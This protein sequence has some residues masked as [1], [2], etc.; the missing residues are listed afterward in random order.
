MSDRPTAAIEHPADIQVGRPLP[1]ETIRATEC[2]VLV[3]CS[4]IHCHWQGL[5]PDAELAKEAAETHYKHEGRSGTGHYGSRTYTIVRL[6]DEA[7][8]QTVDESVLGLSVEE[9]RLGRVDGGVREVE[10]PRTTGDVDELVQRGDRIRISPDRE[11]KVFR[12]SES[13]SYGL[14]TWSV[15]FCDADV[16]LLNDQLPPRG[17]NEL[18]AQ[19]GWVYQSFGPDP[20]ATPAFEV[21]GGLEHQSALNRFDGGASA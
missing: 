7:T 1:R 15:G 3:T 8:A 6:L 12:V 5:F 20:L 11:Q 21:L 16:D 2:G 14:P 9:N 10:F 4:A 17:K 18:I 13:R 19:D